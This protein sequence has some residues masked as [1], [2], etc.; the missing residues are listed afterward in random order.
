MKTALI[1]GATSAIAVATAEVLAAKGV[2]LHLMA[3]NAGRVEAVARDLALRHGL[4]AAPKT[5]AV[6]FSDAAAQVE[7]L[8]RALADLG[9]HADVVLIAHGLLPDQAECEAEA[10][11]A[12]ACFEVNLLSVVR[13]LT[14]LATRYALRGEGTLAVITSVAGDRG[15]KQNYCYGAAKAGLSA[16]LSG[17]RN[18]LAP[19]GVAVLDIRPGFVDTPMTAHMR[20][21]V[22]FATPER[23]ARD[24]VRAVERRA[25]VLYTPWF[26]RPIMAVIRAI[27]ERVFKRMTI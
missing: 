9:G 20:R 6:D 19:K 14:P 7:A 12:E 11:K 21:G 24:I 10:G 2:R 17:L 18:R 25:D 22:L 26:W 4:E 23:V 15:R 3:R 16:F 1:I 8:E 27:P 13:F 5:Q